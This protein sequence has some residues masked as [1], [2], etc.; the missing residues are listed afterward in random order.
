M[1]PLKKITIATM[2]TLTF[3]T[4]ALAGTIPGSRTSSA[5][6]TIIGSKTGTIVGS[7]NGT[8]TGS[9]TGTILGSNTG[10]IPTRSDQRLRTGVQ[11]EV[12]STLLSLFSALW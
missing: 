5:R 1:K 4:V 7:R 8:I 3:A 9:R 11:D 12:L 6:G 2:L 10:I